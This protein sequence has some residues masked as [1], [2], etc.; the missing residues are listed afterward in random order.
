M[1]MPRAV[2]P[3]LRR[4]RPIQY[5][6]NKT[7]LL[8]DIRSAMGDLVRPGERVADLFSGTSVVGRTLS[9]ENPITAVDIQAYAEV[10]GQAM[11]NGTRSDFKCID[12]DTLIA[13]ARRAQDQLYST[14][15]TQIDG[16]EIALRSLQHGDPGPISRMIEG[17]SLACAAQYG[18]Q[19][20]EKIQSYLRKPDADATTT[21]VFGGVYFSYRQAAD[22]DAIAEAIRCQPAGARA[23]LT[24]AL[25][26]VCSDVVNT[27]GKQF[28]QPIRL[29][30][31]AGH[32]KPL[33]IRRTIR[34]RRLDVFSVFFDW[35]DRWGDVVC[36]HRFE[37]DVKRM[38][39]EEYLA[40]RP[41]VSAFYADPPYTIDH[42]SRFYHVL[43]TLTLRD[44]PALATMRKKGVPMVMRGLYRADRFQSDFSIPSRVELAFDRLFRGCS[45]AGGHLLLS[46]SGHTDATAQ[47][48]RCLAIDPLV[49]LAKRY[50]RVVEVSEPTFEGYRKLNAA[51]RNSATEQRTER[52]IICRI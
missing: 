42:Y 5:L 17:G 7:R 6:G 25:L 8:S 4:F 21:L 46:Y 37:N 39:T 41:G 38:S 10:L 49:M 22:L 44:R 40:Q 47:R 31:N 43:E 12:Y 29:M 33:L 34:D 51:S 3:P 9:S 16:E 15:S 18:Q 2:R 11:L 13:T 1:H 36:D 14:F 28:A 32:P 35:L 19:L 27:V 45:N 26:G 30:D 52:L 48:P 20:P 24:A 23:I 50:Y